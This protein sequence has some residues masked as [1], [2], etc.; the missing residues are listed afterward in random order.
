MKKKANSNVRAAIS[1][2]GHF[3][4][5]VASRLGY[6]ESVFSRK[7]RTELSSKEKK[8]LVDQIKGIKW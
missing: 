1:K 7:L 5:E 2:S 8:E 6:G 4:W 3:Q